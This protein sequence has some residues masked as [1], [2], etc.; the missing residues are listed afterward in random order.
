[1]AT[2]DFIIIGA[3]SAGSVLANRLS[4][5]GRYSVL[6]LE[7]GG[8]D[9]SFWLMMPIGYGKAFYDKRYNWMYMTEPDEGLGGRP[10]Y[11]PRGKALGGSSA[12]NAMIFVRGHR[13]DFDGWAAMGNPGWGF[14][15]VLP[16]FKKLESNDRGAN[17][18]RGGDGPL[19]IESKD[20]DIHP[21]C[22]NF[23]RASTEAGFAEN[24]DFNG[25]S[26]EGVGIYQIT[27][28]GGMRMSTARAYLRPALKRKNLKVET[29]AFAEK[30]LFDGNRAVGVRYRQ[31]G[32]MHEASARR[33]VIVSAGAINSPL[34][35]QHSGIGPATLLQRH[36]IAVVTPREG[37][38]RHLQD[39]LC[40][41]YMFTA[42]VPTLNDQ[43]SPLSG[44][45]R[46]G[47]QY[48]LTRTGPL[49]L[50]INHAG[51]FVRSRP[52]LDAP[53]MQLFFSP[54]SYSKAPPGERPL[55]RPDPFSGFLLGVQPTRP[56]S[57]GYLEIRNPDPL[58]AP[59][60]H[61]NYLSTEFDRQEMIAASRLVRRL[62]ETPSL[63]AIIKSEVEPGPDVRSDEELLEDA[64]KRS[65]T[66]FHP[67]STC[68]MGPDPETDVVDASLRVYG[69]EAL[70][71]IDASIFP[72]LT[73]GNTNAPTIMVAEKAA[74]LV[75]AGQR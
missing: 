41:D 34:L 16:Y 2:F 35:L 47:L 55:M 40:I 63:A 67:V 6:L 12:I 18:M 1:M 22:G 8:S 24:D 48:L 75:L 57:R 56:T 27:T 51:G 69:T 23:I 42:K 46:F 37:V 59:V 29:H 32:T 50:G 30:I 4:E 13:S 9:R 26:L 21:T 44:R 52:G 49:S 25:A 17:D 54:M 45:M 71:V 53:N 7:A 19:T 74:D 61:P 33:E 11:W 72:T 64:R 36:G 15:D 20:K 5:N 39:H 66:V 38:G 10:S 14:D 43:L 62:A 70:R 68:R 3:G 58:S 60:I 28:R 73:C 31:N 65:G